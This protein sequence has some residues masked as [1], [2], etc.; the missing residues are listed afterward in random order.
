MENTDEKIGLDMILHFVYPYVLFLNVHRLTRHDISEPAR[1]MP[2]TVCMNC[3]GHRVLL[4]QPLDLMFWGPAARTAVLNTHSDFTNWNLQPALTD[5]SSED[6][7]LY[8]H[9]WLTGV[10]SLLFWRLDNLYYSVHITFNTPCGHS[11]ASIC[12]RSAFVFGFLFF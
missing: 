6:Q 7:T 8:H 1:Q 9:R 11:I 5:T 10:L 2:I 12:F 3:T 4:T